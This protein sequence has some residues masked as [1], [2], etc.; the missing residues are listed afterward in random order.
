MAIFCGPGSYQLPVQSSH[1]LLYP[2][3]MKFA[4]QESETKPLLSKDNPTPTFSP[5]PRLTCALYSD[6]PWGLRPNAAASEKQIKCCSNTTAIAANLAPEP[7]ERSSNQRAV[8]RKDRPPR[9]VTAWF[10]I[11]T[12]NRHSLKSPALFLCS[13]ANTV[14]T[15]IIYRKCTSA[16]FT[17]GFVRELNAG[18]FLKPCDQWGHT[19][20]NDV[21][22]L[23]VN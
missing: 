16:A 2:Y 3:V 19:D 11:T 12:I 9:T 6:E 20:T 15:C 18:A 10:M 17:A 13:A 22:L 7:S 1:T 5:T 23:F 8:R 21:P 14:G 4:A